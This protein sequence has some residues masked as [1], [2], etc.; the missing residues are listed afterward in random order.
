VSALHGKGG[1]NKCRGFVSTVLRSRWT[2]TARA[3]I[4]IWTTPL[5]RGGLMLHEWR[6]RTRTFQ[7]LFG[8]GGGATGVD[9]DFEARGLENVGAWILGRNMFGP[10][11]GDWPDD[12]WNR[13]RASR[14]LPPGGFGKRTTSSGSVGGFQRP[15]SALL[16]RYACRVNRVVEVQQDLHARQ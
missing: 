4:R 7:E 11:R 14:R 5:R 2:V 13:S 15:R 16:S 10:I 9:D 12:G 6:S 1:L 8:S 3:L